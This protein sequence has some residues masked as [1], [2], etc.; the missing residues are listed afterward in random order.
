MKTIFLILCLF[1]AAVFAAPL[2]DHFQITY[3]NGFSYEIRLT[4]TTIA[5]RDLPSGQ[6]ET[7]RLKK[8]QLSPQTTILQWQEQ[9][10]SFVTLSIQHD[11]VISS[12]I[13]NKESWFLMGKLI[14]TA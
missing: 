3:E 1:T 11:R 8:R 10:G 12:G 13:A 6:F 9:D 2:A 4:D 7:D 14:A 5:W